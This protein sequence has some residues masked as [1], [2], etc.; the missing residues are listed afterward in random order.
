MQAIH[1]HMAA[2]A[3]S[4]QG[5]SSTQLSPR[6]TGALR[7]E[8]RQ[9]PGH[10]GFDDVRM[11]CTLSTSA[12]QA[13]CSGHGVVLHRIIFNRKTR[14]QPATRH[15]HLG[16]QMLRDNAA[17]HCALI[18][19]VNASQTT[20]GYGGLCATCLVPCK[21]DIAQ[22]RRLIE[23]APGSAF[24]FETGTRFCGCACHPGTWPQ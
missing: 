12:Q 7:R 9:Q 10:T 21:S 23:L 11:L 2:A 3:R 5:R 4:F 18:A 15:R 16:L 8:L 19:C 1:A 14:T 20:V 6:A 17:A 22:S 13:C 24:K